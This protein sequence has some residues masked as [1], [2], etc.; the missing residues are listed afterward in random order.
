MLLTRKRPYFYEIVKLQTSRRFIA[1][2]DIINDHVD[3]IHCR[4]LVLADGDVVPEHDPGDGLRAGRRGQRARV[5]EVARVR[6]GRGDQGGQLR[7]K[8]LIRP[9][10]I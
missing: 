6:Q 5:G 3:I 2:V 1:P 10:N 9:E 4:H 8:Y 7:G